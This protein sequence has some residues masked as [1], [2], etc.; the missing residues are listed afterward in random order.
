MKF[1]KGD[2]VQGREFA[3]KANYVG[4]ITTIDEKDSC[5]SYC[6][7]TDYGDRWLEN[8]TIKLVKHVD[9]VRN[10]ANTQVKEVSTTYS[11]E[12]VDEVLSKACTLFDNDS[13][14]LAYLHGYFTK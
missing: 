9:E 12:Q 8:D 14:R 6:I 5:S 10:S 1:K 11:Q 7:S 4:V 3:R 13:Q 2:L